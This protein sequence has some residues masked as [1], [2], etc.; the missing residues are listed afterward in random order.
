MPSLS[1]LAALS[2]A[3]FAAMANETPELEPTIGKQPPD[4]AV[5]LFDGQEL[6]KWVKR[7]GQTPAEWPVEDGAMTVG[8][9]NIQSKNTFGDFQLHIEFQCPYLPDKKGQAR[10]NSGVY[11]QG[12]YEVQVLDSYGL[13]PK[14]NDCG[15]IYQQVVPSVNAC[16]PPLQ[17]QSYDITFR[18]ARVEGDEVKEKARVTI[19]H[20]GVK[21][22]DNAEIEPTPGGIGMDPK[23]DGP[24]LLQDHG[25]K[26]RFQNIWL[27]PATE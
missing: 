4:G 19:V 2:M 21:T 20:N 15:A 10:G 1:L 8:Q 5:V 27:V 18:A 17:W 26:V 9:G 6:S 7:D 12:K 22:I 16:L 25:D 14:S 24:I 23:G 13:E 3:G 11:L